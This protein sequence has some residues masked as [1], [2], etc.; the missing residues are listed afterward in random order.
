MKARDV[1]TLDVAS[2]SP[3][4]STRDVAQLLLD[5]GISAVPVVDERNVVIGM[6][7]EG[8]LIGRVEADRDARRDWWLALL[9]EGEALNP[10][11]LAGLR[12]PERAARDVMSKQVVTVDED[13][14]I[15]E[16]AR[17]LTTYRIKRVPVLRD[18]RIVG[19]VSR[20]DLVRAIMTQPKPMESRPSEGFLA[21]T[22]ASLDE[23]FLH[24]PR[25]PTVAP[26]GSPAQPDEG[27]IKVTD[28]QRLV[29]DFEH[30]EAI[31]R[32]EARRIAAEQQRYKVREF[33]EQ[34][35]SDEA[36][37]ALLHEARQAAE[38]GQKEFMILRF[39]SQLCSDGGRAINVAEPAWPATLR[40]E[41]AEIYLRW[42]RDL[43]PSGFRLAARVL[44]FPG[45]MPG[46][47]GLFLVW[48]SER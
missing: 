31:H 28:F 30:K 40:G 20:A 7:S 3:E 18:G 22:L 15:T 39:P 24:R 1:M 4:A 46:D 5:R 33:I 6:V 2:V 38:N 17:L 47:I 45:G 36:W 41:A 44:D 29:A 37:R 23:H 13:T 11:F 34:H 35:I 9:A 16:I 26:S 12:T 43:K 19:I 42:E 27:R 14:G 8:D 25:R 32:D 10:D 21:S 48:G